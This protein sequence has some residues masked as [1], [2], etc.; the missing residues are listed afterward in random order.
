MTINITSGPSNG[1]IQYNGVDK[2]IVDSGNVSVTG[3]SIVSGNLT[4]T[5]AG[6]FGSNLTVGGSQVLTTTNGG[7][8]YNQTWQNFPTGTNTVT[9]RQAGSAFTNS[10]SKPIYVSVRWPS[11]GS[12]FS[13]SLTV[14]GVVV[15]LM[16]S[17]TTSAVFAQTV[18]GI[19]PSG[20]TYTITQS[21]S[22]FNGWA[23][24]R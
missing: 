2:I 13:Y 20:S 19:V 16:S 18:A 9:Q 11:N 1:S 14:D 8:G 3:N 17:N 23:E 21:G 12:G 7:L 15:S 5:G 4:V 22:A 6:A 24:L 10:T